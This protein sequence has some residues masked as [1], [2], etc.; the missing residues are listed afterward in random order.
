MHHPVKFRR[1][2][3]VVLDG[4]RSDTIDTSNLTTLKRLRA[5]G[6]ASIRGDFPHVPRAADLFAPLPRAL[7]AASLPTSAFAS[8]PD[9][10]RGLATRIATTLG[11]AELRMTGDDA[12]AILQ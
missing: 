11:V 2:I 5:G 10:S 8:V 1:V 12:P 6:A 7:A 9:Q 3:L 4:L